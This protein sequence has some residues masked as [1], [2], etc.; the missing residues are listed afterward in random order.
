MHRNAYL[1]LVLTALFW[2]A[3]AVA[4][5]LAVGHVSPMLLTTMRWGLAMAILLFIGWSRLRNDWP[6]VRGHL[7]LLVALG[8]L[9]FTVFNMAL[10]TALIH[11]TAINASI[12]QAGT[13]MVIFAANFLLF[14][15]RVT[16]AQIVGFLLSMAGVILTATHGRPLG[17]LGLEVNIG[18]ALMLVAV[19][20]YAIY[21]VMLRFKPA[22]HWQ[23]LM[24]MLTGA[25]FVTSI[26]ATA[27]EFWTGSM[28]VPDARGWGIVLF[29]VLFPSVLAQAFYIRGVELIGANRAGLFFNLVPIFGMLLSIVLLGEDFHLYH[30]VAMV[31]VLG[32]IWLAEY[33][34]RK[35]AG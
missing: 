22:I 28:I 35:M 31:L 21:T 29:T 11:T 1:L 3:N 34:G 7:W 16:W 26:P 25:A 2:G 17:L 15:L 30:A 6:V 9:G 10:Y 19:L 14:R 23:S 4:G 13:P 24:I 18:D 32:G 27:A 5:K 8:G 33:G 20:V 12:E